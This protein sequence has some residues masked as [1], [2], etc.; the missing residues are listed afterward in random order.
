MLLVMNKPG[1]NLTPPPISLKH[2]AGESV[3]DYFIIIIITTTNMGSK[4]VKRLHTWA[5]CVKDI[6]SERDMPVWKKKDDV[7]SEKTSNKKTREHYFCP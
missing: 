6:K 3:A 4:R 5:T 7:Y 2:K 1:V